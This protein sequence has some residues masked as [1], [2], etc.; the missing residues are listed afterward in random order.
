[1][2]ARRAKTLLIALSLTG[3]N[4]YAFADDAETTV[5]KNPAAANRG[6]APSGKADDS[7]LLEQVDQA[8]TAFHPVTPDEL[9]AQR[10]KL[11]QA[12]HALDTYLSRYGTRG[13]SWKKFLRWPQ[14]VAESQGTAAPN[15]EE[16]TM[17][18]ARFVSGYEG[19]ELG[20]FAAVRLA[21]ERY[22]GLLQSQGGTEE[23]YRD[24][25]KSVAEALKTPG[26]DSMEKLSEAA[27]RLARSGR[28]TE[29]L[30]SLKARFNE[31]N[32]RVNVSNRFVWTGIS[33]PIDEVSPL[34]DNILGTMITG[35]GHTLGWVESRLIPDA[36]R[37]SIET[38][39]TARNLARTVG[40]NGPAVIYSNG[41]SQL[42]G[43]KTLVVTS[44]GLSSLPATASVQTQ[45]R[46]TGIGSTKHGIV[47]RLVKKVAAKRIPQ[48]KAKGERVAQQHAERMF[49]TKLD[50]QAAT[51]IARANERFQNRVRLPLERFGGFPEKMHVS[52]SEDYI[53]VVGLQAGP[54]LL[55]ATIPA[56]RAT[57][58]ADLLLRLHESMI[59][60]TATNML[61]GR[62]LDQPE[63]DRIAMQLVGQI[64]DRSADEELREPWSVTFAEDRP[65]SLSIDDQTATI[66]V[67]GTKFTSGTK[68][69]PGMRITAKYRLSR[70]AGT[71]KAV[72]EE[73]VEALPINFV[74]GKQTLSAREAA[75][76]GPIRKRFAKLFKDEFVSDGLRLQGNW[77]RLG[78]VPASEFSADDGWV[79]VGWT[80]NDVP[81]ANPIATDE[82]AAGSV[83]AIGD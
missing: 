25:L 80:Q 47:D 34:R 35:T 27:A 39:V 64:P 44:Q 33:R 22:I 79:L 72:R 78:P 31:P 2:I 59:N 48:E 43:H 49:R 63:I 41:D 46:V 10:S 54:E 36:N 14:L 40:Y 60:N 11:A 53:D 29:L 69:L 71:L 61:A 21:L 73:E 5:E 81:P 76:M 55:G 3:V 15:L 19:L 50:E 16:L 6:A 9:A 56:P 67:R 37:A 45:S 4:A 1:M 74:K 68:K 38:I 23:Q 8:K 70:E 17:L 57:N 42:R 83:A 28:S 65:V 13:S 24:E 32:V 62:N 75:M 82:P 20:P 58:G 7:K 12:V 26:H 51:M 77:E 18:R 52:S 66:V 30:D